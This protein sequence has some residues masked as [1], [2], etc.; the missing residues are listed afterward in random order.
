MP[1][2]PLKPV[3]L[4]AKK[5][6]GWTCVF[7]GSQVA[8]KFEAR[9]YGSTY[10]TRTLPLSVAAAESDETIRKIERLMNAGY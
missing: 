2:K 7:V 10:E 9:H 6:A 4:F 5:R 1:K 8:V 3:G